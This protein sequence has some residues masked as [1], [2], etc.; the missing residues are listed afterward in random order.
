VAREG[1]RGD[2]YLEGTGGGPRLVEMQ[3]QESGDRRGA[4]G[5]ERILSPILASHAVEKVQDEG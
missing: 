1:G 3:R 4:P 5:R 2:L